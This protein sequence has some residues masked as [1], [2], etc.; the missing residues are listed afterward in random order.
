LAIQDA[1]TLERSRLD[2]KGALFLRRA[3]TGTPVYV[4]LP[5]ALVSLLRRLPSANPAYFFWSGIGQPQN[6]VHAYQRS[7]RKLFR[8]ADLCYPDRRRKPCRSH[9][10]RDTFAVELLLA[11]VPID[12]ISALLG[13]RS[14]KMTEKHYLPWVKARQRQLT[15]SVRRAWFPEVKQMPKPLAFDDRGE[16]DPCS[17][18]KIHRHSSQMRGQT[19]TK[20]QEPCFLY[21]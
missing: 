18:F 2:P 14:V 17:S 5:P 4:P 15:A 8:L 1:V 6:A 19:L 7:L 11:G 12:Q 16:H 3:K 20:I 13:H 9:M 21:L 10:F